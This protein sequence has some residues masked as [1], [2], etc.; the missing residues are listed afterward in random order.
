MDMEGVRQ[1]KKFMYAYGKKYFWEIITFGRNIF[2]M[3][4]K[5]V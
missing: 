5:E 2:G 1:T 3:D 4:T